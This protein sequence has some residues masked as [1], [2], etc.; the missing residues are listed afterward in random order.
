MNSDLK[1]SFPKEVFEDMIK[2]MGMTDRVLFEHNN[3]NVLNV[4][5]EPE[6]GIVTFDFD[7]S[8]RLDS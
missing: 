3:I 2:L 4:I 7:V 6:M 1:V 8:T 5:W